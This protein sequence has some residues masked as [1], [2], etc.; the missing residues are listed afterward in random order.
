MAKLQ[1]ELDEKKTALM[2]ELNRKKDELEEKKYELEN[3]IYLL[4]SQIYSILCYAGETVKF[5]TV[6]S[7]RKAPDTEPHRCLPEAALSG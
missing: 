3:Q 7:G 2:A 4:D 6:R 5:A 1:R